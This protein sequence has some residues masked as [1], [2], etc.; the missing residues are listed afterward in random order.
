M[1][2]DLLP[3]RLR[4]RVTGSWGSSLT[5][6]ESTASTMDDAFAAAAEGA[7]DGHVVL[8]DEQTG[9]RG[10]HGRRWLS[11]PGCDLY[12][13]VVTRPAIEPTATA[14]VTLATGL[15]V[16]DAVATSLPGRSV[17]VKWPNDIWIERRKCAGILVE[18]RTVGMRLESMIIGVGLNVN[19]TQWPPELASA[20]TSL[21][22]E[23][24]GDEPFDRAETLAKLLSHMERWVNLLVKDGPSV[25]VDALRPNLALV[26]E[27]VRWED[28][29]GLFD[30]IDQDGAAR[31]RTETG[32]VSLHS[33]RIEPLEH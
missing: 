10:A 6:H 29:E 1:V 8:A 25:V 21:R 7:N 13:S 27:Q 15:G 11:P 4:E 23:S 19:R 33:A 20:A 31:V 30:G 9:G 2:D 14:L 3:E 22:A 28:G 18:S 16:R 17:L 32:V 12:F 24:E 26:G 5:V